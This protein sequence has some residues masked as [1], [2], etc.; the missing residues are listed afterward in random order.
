MARKRCSK[1]QKCAWIIPPAGWTNPITAVSGQ[2]QNGVD[3]RQLL[4]GRHVL[5][6]VRLEFQCALQ[7]SG[8]GRYTPIQ[9]TRDGVNW[10]GHHAARAAAEAGVPVDVLV[11]DV[12]VVA[13]AASIL[14]LPVR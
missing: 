14:D 13:A 8:Q 11:I 12:S 3:V 1:L 4:P 10:D 9:V 2:M 6:R 5:I 7:Q